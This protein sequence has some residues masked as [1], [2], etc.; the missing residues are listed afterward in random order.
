[1]SPKGMKFK[2]MSY[3]I[4]FIKIETSRKNLHMISR[5]YVAIHFM[6]YREKYLP[7]AGLLPKQWKQLGFDQIKARKVQL[8]LVV[9]HIKDSTT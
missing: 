8:S 5:S 9:L 1:M 6:K 7:P 3:L 2:N 4:I